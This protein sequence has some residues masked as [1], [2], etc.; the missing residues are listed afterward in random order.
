MWVALAGLVVGEREEPVGR[1]F[2]V[3]RAEQPA[4]ESLLGGNERGRRHRLRDD[5]PGGRDELLQVQRRQGEHVADVVEPVAGVVRRERGVG[6][7]VHAQQ[8]ADGVAVLDAVEP[9]DGDPPGVGVLR[10]DL[11]D[12]VPL[13]HSSTCADLLGGRP[14][15]AL[16]GHHAGPEHLQAPSSTLR[17][18]RSGRRRRSRSYPW[19]SGR[20]GS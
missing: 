5:R 2:R 13:I 19:R 16:R 15:L 1:A 3:R 4:G 17:C 20:N 9:A 6:V 14:R 18:C 8:V 10:V 12:A 11:E 7:E